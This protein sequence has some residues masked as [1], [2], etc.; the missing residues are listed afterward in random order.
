MPLGGSRPRRGRRPRRHADCSSR[1][2]RARRRG[3]GVRPRARQRLLHFLPR[4]EDQD[5]QSRSRDD[6]PGESGRPPRGV[7]EGCAQAARAADAAGGRPPSRRARVRGGARLARRFAGRSGRPIAE[8]RAGRH[9]PAAEPHRVPQRDPRPPGAR[10]RCRRS[11]AGRLVELRVRQRDR[12]RLVSDAARALRL[13]GRKNQQACRGAHRLVARR[14]NGA[15]SSG[16]HAGDARRRPANR[17]TRRRS[18][19]PYLPG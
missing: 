2:G 6:E 12:R 10:R 8:S 19:P 16:P 14:R 1:R 11:A 4:H 13:G 15:D 3:G 17:H 9:V 18:H 7:G 5:R